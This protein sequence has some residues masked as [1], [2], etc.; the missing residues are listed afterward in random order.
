MGELKI[1]FLCSFVK[2][3]KQYLCSY[4]LNKVKKQEGN[5]VIPLFYCTFAPQTKHYRCEKKIS[6]NPYA[7]CHYDD[8]GGGPPVSLLEK[9]QAG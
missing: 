7:L 8:D 9:R 1:C 2:K 6:F 3:G 5:F 4:Y